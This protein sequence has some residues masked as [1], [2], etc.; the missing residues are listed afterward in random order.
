MSSSIRIRIQL[1]SC[2]AERLNGV[3]LRSMGTVRK[4]KL[5][6]QTNVVLQSFVFIRYAADCSLQS[7]FNRELGFV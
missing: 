7:L 2:G 6:R 4:E 1:L 5:L 3:R